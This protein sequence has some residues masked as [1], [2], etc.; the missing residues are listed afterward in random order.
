MVRPRARGIKPGPFA[1]MSEDFCA[2]GGPP[3]EGPPGRGR[4]QRRPA[5]GMRR[6]GPGMASA[7]GGSGDGGAVARDGGAGLCGR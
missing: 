5:G 7:C 6:L 1:W 4:G 3:T 2:C